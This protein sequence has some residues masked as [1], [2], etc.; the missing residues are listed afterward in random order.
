MIGKL[1]AILSALLAP[2]LFWQATSNAGVSHLGF[3]NGFRTAELARS[4]L[5]PQADDQ[6]G[7]SLGIS[8]ISLALARRSYASEPLATTS[9]TILSQSP[10]ILQEP[11]RR[12]ALI[13]GTVR[14]HRRD[15]LAQALAIEE[16]LREAD[17]ERA[18]SHFDDL[19]EMRSDMVQPLIEA[20]QPLL[21]SDEGRAVLADALSEQPV[22]SRQLWNSIPAGDEEFDG[23]L[24]LREENQPNL[25]DQALGKLVAALAQRGRIAEAHAL[26][27]TSLGDALDEHWFVDSPTLPPFGWTFSMGANASMVV[28]AERT[29]SFFIARAQSALLARQIVS[30]PPGQYRMSGQVTPRSSSGAISGRLRCDERSNKTTATRVFNFDDTITVGPDCTVYQVEIYGDAWNA[31]TDVRGEINQVSL[32]AV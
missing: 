27:E 31:T 3:W 32:I 11:E 17:Y 23:Y 13:E 21:V 12:K 26:A 1:L 29:Y 15:K 18:F 28:S 25:D 14:L 4:T 10:S 30:L 16:A 5:T 22:W 2:V 6:G 8:E 19:A 24:T 20:L 9:L 7:V